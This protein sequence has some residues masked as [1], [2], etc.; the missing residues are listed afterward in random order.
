MSL[1]GTYLFFCANLYVSVIILQWRVLEEDCS[2]AAL[3][4]YLFRNKP[5][6]IAIL[7]NDIYLSPVIDIFLTQKQGLTGVI[8]QYI[9]LIVRAWIAFKENL[10]IQVLWTA[11]RKI[12]E[13]FPHYFKDIISGLIMW[14]Q[15]HLVKFLNN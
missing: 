14:H 10:H 5:W 9:P 6:P 12:F 8:P 13:I 1:N 7:F 11:E 4:V 15:L 2:E 3:H